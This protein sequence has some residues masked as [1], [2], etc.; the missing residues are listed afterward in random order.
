MHDIFRQAL[1]DPY[2]TRMESKNTIE[3]IVYGIKIIKEG[4]NIKIYDT[5][6]GGEY[7]K[8]LT[9]KQYNIF[10]VKGWRGGVYDVRLKS[11]QE[12][13]NHLEKKIVDEINGRKNENQL[14]HLKE[15]KQRIIENYFKFPQIS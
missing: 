5:H 13:I 6:K 10:R 1:Q 8:E 7:Y 9:P 3:L 4:N 12:K 2:A 11:Y 15:T 14:K